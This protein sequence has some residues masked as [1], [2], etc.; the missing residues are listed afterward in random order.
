MN[1]LKERVEFYYPDNTCT[2]YVYEYDDLN[3]LYEVKFYNQENNDYE[4]KNLFYYDKDG[5]KIKELQYNKTTN[6]T[7]EILSYYNKEGNKIKEL[8]FKNNELTDE[9]IYDN[10]KNL[11]EEKAYTKKKD[12]IE[13]NFNENFN[14]P[15]TNWLNYFN[16]KNYNYRSFDKENNW[17]SRIIVSKNIF[18]E[19]KTDTGLDY[20]E[21]IIEYY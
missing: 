21:R 8:T 18:D 12:I 14:M 17:L 15:I 11:I 9:C 6:V 3:K 13:I 20:E 4:G 19:M 2:K 5:H 7:G 10:N 16:V 1:R